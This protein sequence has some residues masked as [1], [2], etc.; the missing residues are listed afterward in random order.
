MRHTLT[1]QTKSGSYLHRIAF[2]VAADGV[3]ITEVMIDELLGD[4][5]G[6]SRNRTVTLAEARTYYR[7][8]TRMGYARS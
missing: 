8:R 4:W 7:D 3:R 5:L 6:T 2:N 1:A